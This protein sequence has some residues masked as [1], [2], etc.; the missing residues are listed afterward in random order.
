MVLLVPVNSMKAYSWNCFL[1]LVCRGCFVR[2]EILFDD[3]RSD[4]F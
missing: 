1:F 4:D 2:L 3:L